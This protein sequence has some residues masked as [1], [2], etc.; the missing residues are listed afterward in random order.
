MQ[1]HSKQILW[2]FKHMT[3]SIG[4]EGL[5]TKAAFCTALLSGRATSEADTCCA[6]HRGPGQRGFPNRR[7]RGREACVEKLQNALRKRI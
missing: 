7:Q 5:E 4:A 6:G 2:N 3:S 1:F